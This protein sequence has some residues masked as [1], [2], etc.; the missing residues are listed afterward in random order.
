MKSLLLSLLL[1]LSIVSYS[2][3]TEPPFDGHTWKAPY[4]LAIPTNWTIERFLLPPFFAPEIIY[5][6]V[7]D[8]RFTPG[9]GKVEAEEYWAYTF[10]WYLDSALTVD[11]KSIEKDIK[12]YYTGLLK[13]N[14][15]TTKTTSLN[16]KEV[17]V[18][19]LPAKKEAGDLSAFTGT[20]DML[21][22]QTLK[23]ILLNA[24]VHVKSCTTTGKTILFFELSPKPF[25]HKVWSSLD[26][27]WIDFKCVKH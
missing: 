16:P 17:K 11:S 1:F 23:P 9:W 8:I 7:E 24:K 22:Y 25:S 26:Q 18:N 27:L 20:I 3:E 4:D 13:V 21:D 6:G 19:F 14:S 5:K 2:Q 12:A 10:L 15:D